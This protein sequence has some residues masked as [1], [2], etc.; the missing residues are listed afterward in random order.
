[1]FFGKEVRVF[2]KDDAKE[3]YLKLK[4]RN[5]KEAKSILN[6]IQR[7][8]DILKDNPQYGDPIAKKLIPKSL[9]KLGIKNLY[10]VELSN[11]WRMLYTLEGNRIEILLFVLKIVDHPEYNKLFGYKGQ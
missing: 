4:K 10:R 7:V 9:A 5:D 2:L 11:Y 3:G 1:M 8:R 6:S